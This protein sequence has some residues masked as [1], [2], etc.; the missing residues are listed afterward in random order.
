MYPLYI[1][2]EQ[3]DIAVL[4]DVLFSFGADEALL[5][6]RGGGAALEE[7]FVVD[8]F[9]ADEASLDVGVDLTGGLGAFV[10]FLMVQA[11]TSGSPAVRKDMRPRRS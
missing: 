6:G 11:L 5:T 7:E 9:R 2:S 10:P 1:E 4:H 8:D 3:N